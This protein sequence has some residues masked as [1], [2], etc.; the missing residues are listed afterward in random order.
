MKKKYTTLEE[1]QG[2]FEPK[3]I[4]LLPPSC[5]I[6]SVYDSFLEPTSCELSFILEYMDGGNLYQL[7][8]ERRHSNKPFTHYELKKIL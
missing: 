5:S 4:K 1:C 6:V 2:Q 7:M 3:L 8:H